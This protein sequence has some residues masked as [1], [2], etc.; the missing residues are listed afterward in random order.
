MHSRTQQQN[1]IFWSDPRTRQ[2]EDH[3]QYIVLVR[4]TTTYLWG[5]SGITNNV[6]FAAPL[7]LH[8][9]N[10]FEGGVLTFGTE[11][12]D[13]TQTPIGALQPGEFFSVSIQNIRGVFATASPLESLVR[14]FIK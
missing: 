14:C 7:I 1:D 4:S 2:F 10:D 9:H 3:H 11:T 5:S 6:S 13:G 8:I 12:A